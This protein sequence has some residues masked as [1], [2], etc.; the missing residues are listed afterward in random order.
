MYFF[1]FFIQVKIIKFKKRKID[2]VDD[3][4]RLVNKYKQN[5]LIK[6][7]KFKWFDR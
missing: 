6:L 3:F 2:S 5:M 7:D 1:L 4:D